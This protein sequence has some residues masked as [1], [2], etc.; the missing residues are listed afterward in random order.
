[1]DVLEALFSQ[2]RDSATNGMKLAKAYP[3]DTDQ[4]TLDKLI[5]AEVTKIRRVI[6]A[7]GVLK[8]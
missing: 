4:A 3:T 8:P 2:V 6:S 7:I 5:S 1:M